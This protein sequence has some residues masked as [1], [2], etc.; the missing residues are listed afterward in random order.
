MHDSPRHAEPSN[1]SEIVI[2]GDKHHQPVHLA[3]TPDGLVIVKRKP[4]SLHSLKLGNASASSTR[5]I[6]YRSLLSAT[7]TTISSASH[8]TAT[9]GQHQYRLT[10]C[11]LVTASKSEAERKD[12]AKS[13][14]WSLS[15]T[16]TPADSHHDFEQLSVSDRRA[17]DWVKLAEERAYA[18][19]ERSRKF[20]VVLNPIGGKGLAK[21][22][23][24][25]AVQPV[26]DAAH[27]SYKVSLTGPP[28]SPTHAYQLGL[29]HSPSE[30]DALISISGDGIVHELLNGLAAQPGRGRKALRETPIVVVP[31][32]SGN[33]LANSVVGNDR[34]GDWKA[35]ALVALKG[36]P[37]PIDLCSV[38]QQ[39]GKRIFSFL[40]QAFGLMADLDLGTEHLRFLGDFRFT[41]GY[42]KGAVTRR[43]YPMKLQVLVESSSKNEIA[44]R[45]N[46]NL[47]HPRETPSSIAA[48]NGNEIPPLEYGYP[49]DPLPAEL[50]DEMNSKRYLDHF[51]KDGQ[52][53]GEG[54][55]WTIDL[56]GDSKRQGVFFLYG[57]KMPW[58]SKDLQMFPPAEPAS[59]LLDLCLV[60]PM[61]P[62]E[63][64][65]AM[66]GSDTG[67][68]YH[69]PAV[70]YLKTR[71]YRLVFP[72]AGQHA[73]QEGE[74]GYV[75]IDGEKIEHRDFNVEVHQGLARIMVFDGKLAGSH[76]IQGV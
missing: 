31:T 20:H 37:I 27:V 69:H 7:L 45:Y 44:R 26:L 38:T 25:T 76:P 3:L 42:I 75:S 70:L 67:S 1:A 33:A 65:T 35:C 49:D 66:D 52:L 40:T 74:L 28:G 56:T 23:W 21:R 8:H 14:L 22:A 34:S 41:L 60:A 58:I 30:Y 6:P 13:R 51:P 73:N 57:G 46:E 48:Q 12:K 2:L 29:S 18:G 16:V 64:L 72:H 63:A 61:S 32:G 55:W 24:E 43:R 50:E 4:G 36:N 19:V 62:L 47:A 10:I 71:A 5:L 39:G 17:E 68:L 11:A 15:G 54:K 53:D 9:Q 59:G